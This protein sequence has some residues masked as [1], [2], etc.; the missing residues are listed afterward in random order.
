MSKEVDALKEEN[1]A[2]IAKVTELEKN[3]KD[4][5]KYAAGLKKRLAETEVKEEVV[6]G[7]SKAVQH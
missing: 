2:L 1:N 4:Q 6:S 7:S 5:K 3:V